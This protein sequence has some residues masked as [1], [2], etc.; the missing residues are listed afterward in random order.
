MSTAAI[1][2]TGSSRPRLQEQP[3]R[4]R[5]GGAWLGA[6][7]FLLMHVAC[8]FWWSH[9]GWVLAPD[10]GGAGGQAVRDLSRYP[11]L[12]WLDRHHWVPPL[13][14]AGLC[15]LIGG[16]GGLVWGFFVSSVLSHHATFT[17]N[18]L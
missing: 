7:P 12:R 13:A 6:A 16:W 2:P 11:E 3:S 17:V 10:P 18:S 8:G 1:S 9:V 15:F 5:A 14:L 4:P